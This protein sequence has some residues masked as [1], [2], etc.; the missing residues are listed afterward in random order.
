MLVPVE[1]LKEYTDVKVSTQEFCDAMIMSGSN[2]ETVDKYGE[3]IE[4]VVVG[5]ILSVEKHQDS[6]HLVICMVDV[7]QEEPL[8]IVTGAPNVF[9]GALV[10]TVL[11]GGKLP[12]GIKIKKGKL[13]GVESFGMF[14][15]HS[16]LG[17][18]DKIVP[19][20]HKDGVWILPEDSV[21]GADVVEAF[22]LKGETVDFEITPNRPDC[23]SML[24][25]A[26]EAAATFGE[27]LVYPM[28][29]CKEEGEGTAS[30]Y[31]SVEIK[32]PELCRRYV[33][34]VVTDVKIE[35]SPWWMQ[36]RLMYAGVRPINN[37]VDITNYVMLE[38][39]QPLHA[40]DI[41]QV[42]G[43]KIL[44]DTAAEGE[45]F[46]TLDG[47][48]RKLPA[49]ALLIKDAER[50]VALAGIMGGL[51]SEIEEDTVTVL[52]ESANFTGSGIRST[53]KKLGLRTEAS[54]RFEKGIDPNLTAD[55]AD[56]VCYLIE[57]LG[58]GKVVKGSVD[59]Y[60]T[61][62]KAEPIEVR[63]ARVNAVLGIEL[64][65]EEM[66]RIFESL[67]MKV[68][69]KGENLLVTA[70]TVR[71][72][73]EKEVDFIEEVARIYGYN[74][75]PTTLPEMNCQAVKSRKQELRDLA[76]EALV[77]MGADEVQTYSFVSP[78]GLDLIRVP[79]DAKERKLIKLLNPLGEDTSIMRTTL[80]PN[81]L[82]VLG[83]N[84]SRNNASIT[85]FEIGNTFLNI[86]CGDNFHTESDALVLGAYGGKMDFFLLKGMVEE[87]LTKLGVP[88]RTYQAESANQ[89]FHP[90]RCA[91]IL[92][93]EQKIGILGEI[94]PEVADAY[95]ISA[96]AYCCELKFEDLVGLANT[97]IVYKP[98]PKYPASS[99]DIALLLDESVEAAKVEAIIRG[100]AG[101]L[102]ESVA[103]FD[104][105]RGKQV[106]EG[107]KSAA[108]TMAYR[109]A[110]HTLTEE[111]VVKAHTK[112]L[113][114]LEAELGAALRE[115]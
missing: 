84:A 55:A 44:V 62:V 60:P 25:M 57:L 97:E 73:M 68:E 106:P 38:Y 33:A 89:A 75:L 79:E 96:K 13:R 107:K 42:K 82:E 76:K 15:S 98:L 71:M 51:N 7:G 18:P 35:E 27:K 31:I 100:A 4:N 22:Q 112:V 59:C 43:N 10:P 48:E 36:K 46:T 86:P 99:R 87:L 37:I 114:A 8:Q 53:S 113:K 20:K 105:Y 16:E 2:L 41:R 61:P 26:R 111:E 108:F 95:G 91:R 80:L 109:A 67:E 74:N 72:D 49:D 58:A 81:M 102:L 64:S 21:P 19:V 69:A 40:F 17:Y 63:P 104:V 32:K 6:D 103:L 85:A 92:V 47:T 11:V 45:T 5:K 28:T 65:A 24:G 23:L 78:K 39:G 34:R 56:R 29:Q 54:A 14:C 66:T 1:W 90:G 70:P 93:G 9:A 30:D 50:G 88:A 115:M 101:S 83:R 110:D 12:G 77:G 94:H 52:V 3:E